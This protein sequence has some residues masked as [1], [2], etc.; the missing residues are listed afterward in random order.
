VFL[1]GDTLLERDARGR[2]VADDAFFLVLN[3]YHEPLEWS[4]PPAL[5]DGWQV[6][7][8]TSATRSPEDKIVAAEPM[9]VGGR[10]IVVLTRPRADD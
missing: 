10:S 2:R 1:N 6:V 9:T 4:L 3:A 7:L 5:G 8:D